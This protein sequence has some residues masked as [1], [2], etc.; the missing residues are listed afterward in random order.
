MRYDR[1]AAV[2]YAQ[3]YWDR[4]CDDGI[5]WRTDYAV[6]VDKIRKTLSAPA[7]DG[8]EARFVPDGRGAEHAVF[9]RE[10]KGRLEEIEIQ[11]WDGLADCAHFL[12]RC[13][14]AGGFS[15]REISVPKLVKH[16]KE[17][18]DTKVLAERVSRER[19]QRIVDSGVLKRGDMLG[20]FNVSPE[21]DYG[22]RR[23]YSH[24]TMF[25]GKIK[26]GDVGRIT[27]HTKSRFG[28]LSAF[29]DAWHLDDPSYLYTLI[30]ISRDDVAQP[31]IGRS[32]LHGWWRKDDPI[33]RYYHLAFDGRA[34]LGVLPPRSAFDSPHAA[35][36]TSGYYFVDGSRITFIWQHTGEVEV[37]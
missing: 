21:G 34:S 8:W 22:G 20:Y 4:P 26:T 18:P 13:L 10:I 24:S 28:G 1:D 31:T 36:L 2:A 15:I 6:D 16:L 5:F 12:S 29:P 17:R 37:W 3:R 25:V 33:A 9:R 7:K 27:C 11:P 30:H 32:G 23:Q 35:A 19:G 14:T